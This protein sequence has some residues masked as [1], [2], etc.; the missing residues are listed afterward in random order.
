MPGNGIYLSPHRKY[1]LDYYSGLAPTEAL[2]TVE[3][4]PDALITGDLS[5]REPEVSV[6][7]VTIV[8]YELLA[9]ENPRAR[10]LARRLAGGG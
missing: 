8:D 7:E 2:L 10:R 1:V 6:R 5:D 3:F 4:D 9:E